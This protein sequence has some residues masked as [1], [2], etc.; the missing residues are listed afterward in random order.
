LTPAISTEVGG[1]SG[2]VELEGWATAA[3]VMATDYNSSRSNTTSTVSDPDSDGDGVGDGTD[4]T[5]VNYNNT[6]SNRSTVRPPEIVDD[7]LDED[8]DTYGAVSRLDDR[9]KKATA[10]AWRSISKRSARTGR[11]PELD[12]EV[13]AALGDMDAALAELRAELERCSSESCVTALANVADRETDLTRAKEHVENEAWAAFGLGGGTDNDILFGEYFLP[14]VTF[15][16]ADSYSAGEQAALY[17]YL[18]GDAVVAERCTLCLPDAEVPGGNGSF[19]AGV[20]PKR[21]MDYLTGHGEGTDHAWVGRINAAA[22]G[23]GDCDDDDPDISPGK[24]CGSSPHFVAEVTDPVASGG[25]LEAVR[26]SDGTLAVM[27]LGPT[28]EGGPSILVC[29]AEGEAYEPENLQGYGT[30]GGDTSRAMD[31]QG[32][33]Q[34]TVVAQVQVQ[35]PGCPHPVPALFYVGR[36]ESDGQLVYSGGWV[37]DDAALYE[38][39]STMLTMVDPPLVVGIAPGDLDGDGYGDA[40]ER[41]DSSRSKKR[42]VAGRSRRGARIDSGT[43]RGLVDAGVLT[44]GGKE[45]Y[46]HYL[47]KRPGRTQE[48][49]GEPII[50]HLALDAPVLHLVNAGEASNEVKFKAGAEL[51]GQVN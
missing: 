5:G 34:D 45:G 41:A 9:L 23:G 25:S 48:T 1:V 39:S 40:V 11:N 28:A 19:R 32:R 51:S 7:Y 12:K 8:N 46:D 31:R 20:T 49:E 6:R 43:V 3:S 36:G 16:P 27:S 22:H 38:T 17:R 10:A 26:A 37:I 13:S 4:G 29:P 15:D 42:V 18:E 33:I 30:L 21:I 24:V 35:P 47:R 44:A 2:E 14:P 50:T